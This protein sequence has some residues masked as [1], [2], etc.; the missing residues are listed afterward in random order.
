MDL[1]T[2]LFFPYLGLGLFTGL[3]V[4]TAHTS[5]SFGLKGYAIL[6]A[7]HVLLAAGG[8]VL[9]VTSKTANSSRNKLSPGGWM[10]GL[11]LAYIVGFVTAFFIK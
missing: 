9:A 5:H 10:I 7:L 8:V 2:L 4:T 11:T 1:L 3:A 6:G